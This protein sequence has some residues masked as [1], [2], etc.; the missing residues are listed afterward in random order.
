MKIR[1]IESDCS[2]SGTNSTRTHPSRSQMTWIANLVTKLELLVWVSR[3]Y[4]L[5]DD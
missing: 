4:P 1:I 2:H 3:E 5:C